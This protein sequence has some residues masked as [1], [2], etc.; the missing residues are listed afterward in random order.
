MA[1][2]TFGA[3]VH[4]YEG[5]KVDQVQVHAGWGGGAPLP[6]VRCESCV[7]ASAAQAALPSVFCVVFGGVRSAQQLRVCSE[8]EGSL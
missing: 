3:S 2:N 7:H 5:V 4:G 6:T 8:H 1:V